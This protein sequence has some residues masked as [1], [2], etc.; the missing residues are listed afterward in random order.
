[1]KRADQPGRL[2]A[3]RVRQRDGSHGAQCPYGPLSNGEDSVALG[4]P[5]VLERRQ[6]GRQRCERADRGRCAQDH[7]DRLSVLSDPGLGPLRR[8]VE[9]NELSSIGARNPSSVG[10]V[11]DRDIDRILGGFVARGSR[12]REDLVGGQVRERPQ[13]GHR[14]S[15]LGERP[16]L[17]RE[18]EIHARGVLHPRQPRDQDPFPGQP[19]RLDRG[20]DRERGGQRDGYRRDE[21]DQKERDQEE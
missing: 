5:L 3:D 16:G 7:A 21:D 2:L 15:V 11:E 9:R 1:M 4:S 19:T 17:V 18:E 8:R 20:G 10:G 14:L 12:K 13:V 6:L